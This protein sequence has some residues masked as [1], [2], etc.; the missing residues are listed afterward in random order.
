MSGLKI[1][2]AA[3]WI[4]RLQD[5]DGAIWWTERG[6]FDP[7]NHVESAMALAAAGRL[8]AARKAFE[9][10]L[11]SQEE[12]GGWIGD[13]GAAAPMDADNRRLVTD[14]APKLKETNF[15]AWSAAGV[16][17][18]Y[19]C[20]GEKRDLDRFGEMSLRACRFAL[21][22]QSEHGEIAWRTPDPGEAFE[23]VD[24]LYA[25]NC[26]IYMALGCAVEIARALGKGHDDLT[27]GRSRLKT[28][29]TA[30]TD[31]FDR[32]W[33]SKARYAMDWYYPVLCGVLTG[34]D[35]VDRLESRWM[36]FVEPRE[37][38]R[39]VSEEPWATAAETAELSIACAQAG[40]PLAARGLLKPVAAL[41]D[42]SGGVWM[43][44]QFALD[45]IWPEERPSWTAGAAILAEHALQPRSATARLF[46]VRSPAEA[47]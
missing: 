25:A 38:C 9:H 28:A 3:D 10:L 37:G 4:E 31:R 29:L 35:A 41:Q 23:Q 32:T 33:P 8:A 47:L 43:G 46:G 17:H 26:A 13:L 44:R 20:T 16:W 14:G 40:R 1:H 11:D 34:Q 36:E 12:D 22:L 45:V 30:R 27:A 19:L 15:A 18:L 7:W 2:R 39:C 5:G 6:L 21:A 42:E 24:A